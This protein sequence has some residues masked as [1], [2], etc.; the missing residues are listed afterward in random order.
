[1][2]P[3]HYAAAYLSAKGKGEAAERKALEGLP[4]AGRE[5]RECRLFGMVR[6]KHITRQ[7]KSLNP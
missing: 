5:S 3:R 4:M 7:S 1:M 2:S 6:K